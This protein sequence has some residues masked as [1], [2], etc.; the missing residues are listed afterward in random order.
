MEGLINKMK[1]V[2]RDPSLSPQGLAPGTAKKTS[3]KGHIT[4]GL[5]PGHGRMR[6]GHQSSAGS[7]TS[8][9]LQKHPASAILAI[10]AVLA[11]G[12][13]S[14]GLLQAQS[15]E[16]FFSYP[17]K[18]TAPV[19]TFTATDPEG[20]GPI[21]WSLTDAQ[22]DDNDI[23]NADI[24]DRDDLEINQSGVLSFMT[25]PNFE[26][27]NGS[28]DNDLPSNPTNIYRVV[29]QA[30]DGTN[31]ERF[32]V[33]VTVTNEDEPGKV[34]WTVDPDAD[35]SIAVI[36]GGLLQFRT[37]AQLV[38]TVTDDDGVV[39][40]DTTWKWYRSSSMSATGTQI[41]GETT[42]TYDVSDAPSNN[43]V[44]SYIRVEATYRRAPPALPRP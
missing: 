23:V 6:S 14:G 41:S 29:V 13:L 12:L 34:T 31:V 28:S 43:D 44:G 42:N 8:S 38:A 5:L 20:A 26:D 32:K 39:A 9:L 15:D 17:E 1:N 7:L 24:V 18:G 22:D 27:P 3:S 36:S 11:F 33:I 37:D 10:L 30:S 21:Y 40:T 2:H 19:A 25:P 4:G 16:Q 35:G